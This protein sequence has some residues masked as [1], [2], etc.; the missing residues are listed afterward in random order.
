MKLSF[1]FHSALFLVLL[2]GSG[3]AAQAQS[4]FSLP[5]E[6][7]VSSS[8]TA[9]SISNTR[10]VGILGRGSIG[11]WGRSDDRAVVGTQ[12]ETSCAGTYAVGGCATSGDGVLGRARGGIG[13][14]G[15]SDRRAIV[16][17]QG[18]TSCAGLYAVG[19][20]ATSGDGIFGRS[21]GGRAGRFDGNVLVEGNVTI[22]G[23]LVKSSGSFKIDHPLNPEGQYLHHAFVES[24]DMMNIYNG[25]VVLN[26][27]GEAWVVLPAWFE[28]L[29]RDFRYQL[30]AVG[31]PGPDLYIAETISKNRFKIAGGQPGLEVSW[32]VTGVRHDPYAE[33]NRVPVETWK[34]EAEQGRY[35]HPEAYG[36]PSERSVDFARQTKP[37]SK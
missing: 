5:Y 32:Q 12:G 11:I 6:Q 36:Q 35:L 24:P 19:G 1:F 8:S 14:W 28:A 15:R 17:T 22:V 13:V 20:C 23:N 33:A 34:S 37:S 31:A 4:D 16:G 29:N 2:F 26:E 7:S 25:N 21:R 18:E 9:L 3:K 10:G 30:T 27:K